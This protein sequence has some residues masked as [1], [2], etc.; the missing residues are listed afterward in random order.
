V[1]NAHL[2]FSPGDLVQILDSPCSIGRVVSIKK[3]HLT[4]NLDYI[5]L[6]LPIKKV[7]PID[8]KSSCIQLPGHFKKNTYCW[9]EDCFIAFSPRLDLHGVGVN[10]ALVKLDK[11][12]DQAIVAGHQQLHIIHGKGTGVLRNA[13]RR[14]LNNHS[15][16]VK[17]IDQHAL[18]GGAGVTLV[19][20]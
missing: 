5:Q 10:E 1:E 19:Q 14:F 3:K 9:N 16:V 13:V 11:F 12:I 4:V 17:M 15:A 2:I 8:K 20:L 6:T 18:P 7:S